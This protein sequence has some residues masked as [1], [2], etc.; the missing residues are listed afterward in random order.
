V[1][2]LG[3]AIALSQF[4]VGLR[5]LQVHG[6]AEWIMR[7]PAIAWCCGPKECGVVPEGGVRVEGDGWFV[8][9]TRQRFKLG[10]P[11]TYWSRDDRMWWCRTKGNLTGAPMEGPVQC[12]FVPKLGS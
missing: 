6:E 7:D 12:L 3:L 2:A 8:P 11:H 4:S 10:D 9:A 1:L 5:P